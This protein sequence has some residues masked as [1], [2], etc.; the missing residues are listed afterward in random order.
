[1]RAPSCTAENVVES[2]TACVTDAG[3]G[4]LASGVV[5]AFELPLEDIKQVLAIKAWRAL[6]A[7][8]PRRARG[9]SRRK[10]V[11]MCARDQAKDLAGRRKR[12]ELFIEDLATQ[13]ASNERLPSRDSFDSRY[14]SSSHEETYGGVEQDDSVVP[15]HAD[16][17]RAADRAAPIP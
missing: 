4:A 5:L 17:S 9:L 7:Y 2:L 12:H 8:D 15:E 14:L 13:D 6:V 16:R 11:F 10:Y 3:A 1:M